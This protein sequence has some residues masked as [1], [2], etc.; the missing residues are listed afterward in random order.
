MKEPHS[1][2]SHFL[3][4]AACCG[5]VKKIQTNPS[6]ILEP[7]DQE[8]GEYYVDVPRNVVRQILK[9]KI[10]K[11]PVGLGECVTLVSCGSFV[12]KNILSVAGM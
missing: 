2:S 3:V 5:I 9:L 7:Q 8:I 11:G 6:T 1:D 4:E 10:V 12:N